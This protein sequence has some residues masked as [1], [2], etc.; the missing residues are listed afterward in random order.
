MNDE[1]RGFGAIRVGGRHI[2]KDLPFFAHRLLFGVQRR[3]VSTKNFAVRESH[4]EFEGF[5]FG[6]PAIRE[7]EVDLVIGP[8]GDLAIALATGILF[9]R[10]YICRACGTSEQN[11][12]RDHGQQPR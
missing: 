5:S 12:K 9:V 11:D 1:N 10:I 7:I 6:I 2:N 4:V 3:I 8:D